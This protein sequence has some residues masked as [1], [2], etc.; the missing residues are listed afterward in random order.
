MLL[1][2]RVGSGSSPP[3]GWYG[4]AEER[5]TSAGPG[6]RAVVLLQRGRLVPNLAALEIHSCRTGDSG[7]ADR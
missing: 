3:S 7:A 5:G 6:R 4:V 2:R 1:R